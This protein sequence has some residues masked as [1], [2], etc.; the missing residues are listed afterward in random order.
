MPVKTV[1]TKMAQTPTCNATEGT[2]RAWLTCYAWAY[3]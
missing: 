3:L 1:A 2:G